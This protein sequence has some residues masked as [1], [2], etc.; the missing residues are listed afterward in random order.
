[1]E[2][3][4]RKC[5]PKASLRL[6]LILVNNPKQPLHTKNSFKKEDMWKEDYQIAF[7]KLNL[8]FLSNPAP[9]T[10]QNLFY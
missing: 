4:Y 1:M 7:K 9:F 10:G 5:A 6:F 2:K 3:S 8:F